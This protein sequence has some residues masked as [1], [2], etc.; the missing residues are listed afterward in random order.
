[1]RSSD[2]TRLDVILVVRATQPCAQLERLLGHEQQ[3]KG[4]F[5]DLSLSEPAS[6]DL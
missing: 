6:A 2:G 1:M 3:W 5:D 4:V